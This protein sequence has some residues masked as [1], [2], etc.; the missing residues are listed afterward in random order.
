MDIAGAPAV[1]DV[2]TVESTVTNLGP[3]DA[4]DVRVRQDLPPGLDFVSASEG[5]EYEAGGGLP[6]PGT[7]DAPFWD[8]RSVDCVVDSIAAGSTHTFEVE[9]QRV[10]GWELWIGAWVEG[11]NYDENYDNDYSY[12]TLPA[13]PIGDVGPVDR[14]RGPD[15]RPRGR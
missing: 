6:P 7:S 11:A 14:V 4:T 3:T 1:G 13:D 9:V 12:V 5:C 15:G 10:S 2:L 8:P